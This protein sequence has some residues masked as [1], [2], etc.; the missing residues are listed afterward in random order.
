MK[1]VLFIVPHLS[2]GGMPQ[3]TYDL[4]RKIKGEVDVYCVEYSMHSSHF[5]VQRNKIIELL[6]NKFFELGDNKK[7]LM[8]IIGTITPDIVHLQE[9]PEY[10][11]SNEVAEELY[12]LDRN[13]LIVETSHDSS[14]PA[15]AKRFYPDHF[16]LISEYQRNEF[17]KLGIPIDLIESDIEHK[18]RKNREEG[19][20][21]LGLD[22]N[23]KHVLNVGLFTPRKNQAE[24]IEYARSLEEY[25]IQF[26][27]VGNQADNFRDYW[28][29]ILKNL[30]SNVK[31]WGERSDVE[32][33]YSCMDLMLFTSRGTGNDKETSPLVIREA[34]GYNLPSLIFNLPVYL[35][36]YDKYETIT[37]LDEN[38][39]ETNIQKIVNKLSLNEDLEIDSVCTVIS[40]Y[41]NT[42]NVFDKTLKCIGQYRDL[43][44]TPIICCNHYE[45]SAQTI[46]LSDVCDEYIL[47]KNNVLTRNNFYKYFN[48]SLQE[49][50]VFLN[51]EKSNN[52]IY[53][54]P[55]VYQNY[56]N[57][58]KR[59]KDLGFKYAILSNFDVVIS[60][61]DSLK[62]K[63]T[64]RSISDKDLNG[65]FLFQNEKEGPTLKTVFC[66]IKVETFMEVFPEIFTES[67]YNK[68]QTT[69]GS[70]TNNLENIFYHALKSI[71]K[72]VMEEKHESE[73]LTS[74]ESFTNSQ[75]DYFSILPIDDKTFGLYIRKSNTNVGDQTLKL[76]GIKN[77]AT[78]ISESFDIT[79]QFSKVIEIELEKSS[80]YQF[81]LIQTDGDLSNTKIIDLENL[82][83]VKDNGSINR[84]N[85]QNQSL[86]ISLNLDENKINIYSNKTFGETSNVVVRDRLTGHVVYRTK[87]SFVENYSY[88]IMPCQKWF[89]DKNGYNKFFAGYVLDIYDTSNVLKES[90]MIDVDPKTK[91]IVIPKIQHNPLNTS[92]AT[93]RE[94]F[95]DGIY[96]H[97]VFN[98]DD[99][100]IAIDVGANDGLFTDY[101][102]Q[103]GVE[104]VY[105]VEADSR[106]SVFLNKKY[107]DNKN[108]T[109]IDKA[110][111]DYDGQIS[112]YS[113][114]ECT[115]TSS[116]FKSE[117]SNEPVVV[118]CISFNT[119]LT[120]NELTSVDM[121]K[122]DIEGGEYSLIES[123]DEKTFQSIK[124]LI[125]E[126]HDT[127]V[128]LIKGV[129]EKLNGFNIEI[130]DHHDYNQILDI[131]NVK[132]GSIVT[133]FGR[134][135]TNQVYPKIKSVHMILEDEPDETRQVISI[136][137]VSNVVKSG[138]SYKQHLNKRYVDFPPKSISR[139]PNDVTL[140]KKPYALNPSHFG[141]YS[142]MKDAILSEFD[143]DVDYLMLF[144]G[145]AYI[146]NY[147]EFIS[148]LNK[149]LPLLEKN[150]IGYIS[151][152]GKHHLENGNVISSKLENLNDSFFVC[153]K[154][155]GCQCIV[156]PSWIREKL[157]TLLL[158]EKWDVT[159]LYF[160][161]VFNEHNIK[162]AVSEKTYVTQ[163]DGVSMIDDVYKINGVF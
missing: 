29:P 153:D 4:M 119:L 23:L 55:A 146:N 163:S 147:D 46:T 152:G 68:L 160:N 116:T 97:F 57:G 14:F 122:I 85:L 44:K 142:S 104:R 3:Y 77:G 92:W 56:F 61:E 143:S 106:S 9:V 138:I 53:H 94:T 98:S 91:T 117:S 137:S 6:G 89:L 149:V 38:Y 102:L 70:E 72:I 69:F 120:E 26:H 22:P 126:L 41:T 79:S 12:S 95:I 43:L 13:Y 144:E 35:G 128:N 107:S 134:N 130:R 159:D 125:I 19:L 11:M 158:T 74:K 96:D 65:F 27:F 60:K 108:I 82:H 156:F 32:N 129:I 127:S 113:S 88:W 2:T 135:K 105:M 76:I 155:I 18:P 62:I 10:F 40:T 37:Y 75:V 80:S 139:R 78:F 24:A 111:V 123:I 17:S 118:D 71:D 33:F 112:F 49:Y 132:D 47:D 115:T 58:V 87:M 124:Y 31:I 52:D 86:R 101:L 90:Y 157:K 59:A 50:D 140:E 39:K 51:L 93:F 36:M 131:E 64:L 133:L 20:R 67:D 5:V 100:K 28:E 21:T 48:D 63:R 30:P 121:M 103:R 141:C 25:P 66:V 81:K 45:N 109:V 99:V 114:D 110:L 42:E 145:D 161:S 148:E 151:F 162:M 73:F 15:Y 54:G 83:S 7:D 84:K 34:I 8:D 150:K 154:I 136:K 1:K 16:A